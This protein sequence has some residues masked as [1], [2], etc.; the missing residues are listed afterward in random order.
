MA[1]KKLVEY[2]VGGNKVSGKKS[3][4]EKLVGKKDGGEKVGGE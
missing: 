1:E 4:W 2:N 3:W